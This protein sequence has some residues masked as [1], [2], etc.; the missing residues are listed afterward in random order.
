ML[1]VMQNLLRNLRKQQLRQA[2]QHPNLLKPSH[3]HGSVVFFLLFLLSFL[4]TLPTH[5]QIAE[6]SPSDFAE[7][8]DQSKKIR[9]KVPLSSWSVTVSKLNINIVHLE[10]K[11]TSI[12]LHK[13]YLPGNPATLEQAVQIRNDFL[14]SYL[15]NLT[16]YSKAEGMMLGK[17]KAISSTYED[18]G[19]LKIYREIFFQHDGVLYLLTFKFNKQ[20]FEQF[21]AEFALFMQNI[22]LF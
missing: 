19:E 21:K 16:F 8:T 12:L 7:V 1:M 15:K 6:S 18:T 14:G 17:Q 3:S 11:D 9:F 2:H 22:E 4:S 10:K 5:A 13:A 20:H